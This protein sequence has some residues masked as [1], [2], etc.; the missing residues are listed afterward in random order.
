MNPISAAIASLTIS[1]SSSAVKSPSSKAS[2]VAIANMPNY[3]SCLSPSTSCETSFTSSCSSNKGDLTSPVTVKHSFS[4]PV[5][6][7]MTTPSSSAK[8]RKLEETPV[9]K[10]TPEQIEKIRKTIHG[11]SVYKRVSRD[12][13]SIVKKTDEILQKGKKAN[14]I[15]SPEVKGL[16]DVLRAKCASGKDAK[17]IAS[18]YT[19]N[20]NAIE[21]YRVSSWAGDV[22]W[23]LSQV[24]S[25]KDN[26]PEYIDMGH[27]LQ[28]QRSGGF[29]FCP[30]GDSRWDNIRNRKISVNGVISGEWA[31]NNGNWK[32]SSFFPLELKTERNVFTLVKN[33]KKTEDQSTYPRGHL[34][35]DETLGLHIE[36]FADKS[37]GAITKSAYP[38]FKFINSSDLQ[39]KTSIQITKESVEK[40]VT[41]PAIFKTPEEVNV[42]IGRFCADWLADETKVFTP[43][44]YTNVAKSTVVIDIAS[45]LEVGVPKGILA[46]VPMLTIEALGINRDGT[47]RNIT[48][49][50]SIKI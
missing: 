27:L 36:A 28:Q 44:S 7:G 16:R 22:E 30:P 6:S 40:G 12:T 5:L 49:S 26:V 3:S 48:T 15:A 39:G 34:F 33:A 1:E 4:S 2:K 17:T 8:K 45:K 41:S 31:E 43:F 25:E 20:A 9:A 32:L 29:H 42:A 24:R 47:P 18:P 37:N 38:I 11:A 10:N 21:A 19:Q 35:R 46:E 13:Q 50:S 14:L 23:G